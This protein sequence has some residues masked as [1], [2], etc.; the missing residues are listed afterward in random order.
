M[1]DA[2]NGVS[3]DL[4]ELAAGASLSILRLRRVGTGA[5]ANLE[6]AFRDTT[7]LTDA[8]LDTVATGADANLEY[9]FAGSATDAITT[10]DSITNVYTQM[11]GSVLFRA[12][13]SPN[14]NKQIVAYDLDSVGTGGA[15]MAS[16]FEGAFVD[17]KQGDDAAAHTSEDSYVKITSVSSA[18]I[19]SMTRFLYL[20]HD[21]THIN[22]VPTYDLRGIGDFAG[23][24]RPGDTSASFDMSYLFFGRDR[25]TDIYNAGTDVEIGKTL[26]RT[27]GS[28]SEAAAASED[29]DDPHLAGL[30]SDDV[31]DDDGAVSDAQALSRMRSASMD[32]NGADR[33]AGNSTSAT[34]ETNKLTKDIVLRYEQ[35]VAVVRV[36]TLPVH[37][38]SFRAPKTRRIS[39]QVGLRH[40]RMSNKKI[41]TYRLA[42]TMG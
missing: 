25:V 2:G 41:L 5:N 7:H 32:G 3:A 20:E 38:P 23:G 1:T 40:P 12:G 13:V 14:D 42:M 36:A 29:D 6:S 21:D 4:S 22:S 26:D 28:D 33:S 35:P 39:M 31:V 10:P 8:Y 24:T 15:Y 17:T 37:H 27:T 19:K 16:M 30:F 9:A 18:P 34:G 11:T